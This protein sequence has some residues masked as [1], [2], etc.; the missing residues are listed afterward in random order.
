[1]RTRVN[2]PC[3]SVGEKYDSRHALNAAGGNIAALSAATGAPLWSAPGSAAAP[4]GLSVS[5]GVVY[6]SDYAGRI[7]AYTVS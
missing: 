3:Y 2:G 5:N 7:T 6:T 4:T 1:V